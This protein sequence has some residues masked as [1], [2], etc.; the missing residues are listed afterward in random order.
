MKVIGSMAMVRNSVGSGSVC[1]WY[2]KFL[3]SLDE[4]GCQ[5]NLGEYVVKVRV[6]VLREE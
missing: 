3:C 4:C 5:K 1:I 6:V 2:V